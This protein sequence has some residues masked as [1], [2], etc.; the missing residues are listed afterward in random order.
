MDTAQASKWL[1]ACESGRLAAPEDVHDDE[2]WDRYWLAHIDVGPM[3]QGFGD[4][5][6]SDPGFLPSLE[7]RTAR[8]ILC[9]GNGLSS[10]CWALALHGFQ[11]TVLDL[12]HIPR[13]AFRAMIADPDNSLYRLPGLVVRGEDAVAFDADAAIGAED[14]PPMHHTEDFRP[15][16]GGS[17]THVTGDLMREDLCP[18]PYDVVIERR[19]V[20]LFPSAEQPT[21]LDRLAARLAPGGLF[22]SHQHSGGWQPEDPRTH[23]AADWAAARGF[24]TDDRQAAGPEGRRAQLVFTSG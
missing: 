15:R 13:S 2:A 23:F 8:T 9:A 4:M 11:V 3:E 16:G 21:A 20:Q 22:V 5:M 6:A 17:L 24:A 19:T 1:E 12:S 7:R 18:G 14:C 10:E